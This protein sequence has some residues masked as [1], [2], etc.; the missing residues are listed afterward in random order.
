M[1][2]ILYSF[3][4]NFFQAGVVI[5]MMAIAIAWIFIVS[6]SCFLALRM[7]CIWIFYG[8][9]FI[10]RIGAA[11]VRICTKKP[12]PSQ[13]DSPVLQDDRPVFTLPRPPRRSG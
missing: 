4:M 3:S 2:D 13:D 9:R 8:L 5:T 6:C 10:W 12:L 7:L 1:E 11:L